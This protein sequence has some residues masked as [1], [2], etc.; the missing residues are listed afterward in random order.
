MVIEACRAVLTERC[1]L[2]CKQR[3]RQQEEKGAN[4]SVELATSLVVR[5]STAPPC[6]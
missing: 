5:E 3:G 2:M 1:R 6:R 4:R